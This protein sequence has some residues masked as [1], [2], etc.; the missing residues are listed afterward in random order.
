MMPRRSSL[1][2]ET[3]VCTR[4]PSDT[5]VV[6]DAGF[7]GSARYSPSGVGASAVTTHMRQAPEG[8]RSG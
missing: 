4:I 2:S 7:P 1:I 5:G 8:V 3:F 6:H